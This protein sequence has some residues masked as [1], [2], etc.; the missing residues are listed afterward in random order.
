MLKISHRDL[1]PSNIL[2]FP[3]WKIK[4]SD[5]GISS[6]IDKSGKD[7]ITR[8]GTVMF[9]APEVM[10]SARGARVLPF[11]SDIY[12]LG[13]I[14]CWMMIKGMPDVLEIYSHEI[15]F[16]DVYSRELQ[17]FVYFCLVRLPQDRPNISQVHE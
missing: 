6:Q 13:L 16:P 5:Y 15:E 14:A 3:D 8:C 10:G 1:K 4:V 9:A 7:E 11:A 2:I 17:E 12:S